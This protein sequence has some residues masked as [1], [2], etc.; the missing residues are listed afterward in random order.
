MRHIVMF[1]DGEMPH[2][3]VGEGA[4]LSVA[5]AVLIWTTAKIKTVFEAAKN[6]AEVITA[7]FKFMV[8]I[9]TFLNEWEE[10]AKLLAEHEEKLA[11]L[12]EMLDVDYEQTWSDYGEE[13]SL[14]PEEVALIKTLR[15][16]KK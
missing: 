5:M 14:T 6:I 9:V 11:Y 12:G 15:S 3:G 8:R 1:D 4:G 13:L 10:R 2:L 7:I 16:A